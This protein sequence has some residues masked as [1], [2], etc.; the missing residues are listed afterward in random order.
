M[1]TILRV[2]VRL[3]DARALLPAQHWVSLEERKSQTLS[4]KPLLLARAQHYASLEE[5][6]FKTIDQARALALKT[7]WKGREPVKPTFFGRRAYN[8]VPLDVSILFTTV[9]PI[10]I[11]HQPEIMNSDRQCTHALLS[12]K[13]DDVVCCRKESRFGRE[14]F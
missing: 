6:K 9:D 2:T 13:F 3:H 8:N 11:H 5:R 12:P 4:P 1:T 10:V 7:D 14:G